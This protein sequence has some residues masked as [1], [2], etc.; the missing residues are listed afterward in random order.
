M[1]L[2][3]DIPS[4]V[5]ALAGGGLI[6]L[7]AALLMGLEGR[8]LGISG[9]VRSVLEADPK[10]KGPSTA[11]L[12]GLVLVGILAQFYFVDTLT[13]TQPRSYMITILAGLLV[14]YGTAMGNGCTSGHGVCGLS[15]FSYRSLIATLSFMAAG[16]LTVTLHRVLMGGM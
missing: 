16:M 11:F 10:L 1:S 15:R 7:S 3:S 14:G 8:I 13:N 4:W 5:Q 6:G 2:E 12:L 9:F